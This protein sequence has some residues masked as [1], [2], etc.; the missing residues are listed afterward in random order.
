MKSIS[1]FDIFPMIELRVSGFLVRGSNLT[2]YDNKLLDCGSFLTVAINSSF[3]VKWA[4][5]VGI[6]SKTSLM[7][8]L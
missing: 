3:K 2:I 4:H 8:V 5:T 7:M 6:I 1:N